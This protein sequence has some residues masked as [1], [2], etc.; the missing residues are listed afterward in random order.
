MKEVWRDVNHKDEKHENN[1]VDNLE[2]CTRRYNI[3]YGTG[4]KAKTWKWR[5]NNI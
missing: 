1:N 2:W 3:L 5:N 4:I